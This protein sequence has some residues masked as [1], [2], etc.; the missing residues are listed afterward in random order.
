MN[1]IN[2]IVYCECGNGEVVKFNEVYPMLDFLDTGRELMGNYFIWDRHES[3]RN[4]L[5]PFQ[6][7]KITAEQV[8]RD[9]RFFQIY[10][11]IHHNLRIGITL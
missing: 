3:L 4:N 7:G 8:E 5:V 1:G 10:F 2:Q 6:C 11:I 9:E